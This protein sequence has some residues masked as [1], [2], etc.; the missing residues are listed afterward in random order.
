MNALR[1]GYKTVFADATPAS[2]AFF[3]DAKPSILPLGSPGYERTQRNRERFGAEL[4]EHNAYLQDSCIVTDEFLF[5]RELIFSPY[6]AEVTERNFHESE[7]D[8]RL[9]LGRIFCF[10]KDNQFIICTK[11]C[12]AYT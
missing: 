6:R 10:A 5:P 7:L 1:L 11:P 12:A 4:R 3:K 9:G 2:L 8:N